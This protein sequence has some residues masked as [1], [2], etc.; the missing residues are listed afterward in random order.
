MVA[1]EHSISEYL[2]MIMDEDGNMRSRAVFRATFATFKV[3][4][5]STV[6]LEASDT[7]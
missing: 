7:K 3:T 4:H 1:I 2:K 6:R 5:P